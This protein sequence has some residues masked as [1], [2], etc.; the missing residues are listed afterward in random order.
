VDLQSCCAISERC[1]WRI[2]AFSNRPIVGKNKALAVFEGVILW[3]YVSVVY[4]VFWGCGTRVWWRG[5]LWK[6]RPLRWWCG[7]KHCDFVFYQYLV[8]CGRANIDHY[9]FRYLWCGFLFFVEFTIRTRG[10][11]RVV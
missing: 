10:S 3:G 1:R 4:Q 9:L 7:E 8:E 5:A 6:A 2:F 11:E